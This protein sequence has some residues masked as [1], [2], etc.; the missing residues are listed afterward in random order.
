MNV[1]ILFL[2][3]ATICFVIATVMTRSVLAAGLAFLSAAFLFEAGFR[4]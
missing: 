3:V 1:T 4:L 2:I